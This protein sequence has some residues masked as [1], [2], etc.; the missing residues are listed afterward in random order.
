MNVL[1]GFTSLRF[2]S[3][4]LRSQAAG[5]VPIAQR[6]RRRGRMSKAQRQ[7]VSDRTRKYWAARR[8]QNEEGQAARQCL[9]LVAVGAGCP[10]LHGNGL[11]R[12]A[13]AMGGTE[14]EAGD[15]GTSRKNR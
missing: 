10:Q 8:G 1:S 4:G 11:R 2:Q 5:S 14:S 6:T 9:P 3:C 12:A 7:T 13:Q 15:A